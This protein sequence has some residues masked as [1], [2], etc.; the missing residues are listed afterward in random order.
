MGSSFSTTTTNH[1]IKSIFTVKELSP[2]YRYQCLNIPTQHPNETWL[3]LEMGIVIDDFLKATPLEQ[4]ELLL[5]SFGHHSTTSNHATLRLE[6]L[7]TYLK[8][9]QPTFIRQ[10]NR[11]I[12]LFRYIF[13]P[14]SFI[15]KTSVN[16]HFDLPII[17]S[18]RLINQIYIHATIN[19]S[20]IQRNFKTFKFRTE[21]L[22]KHNR[23][24]GT[25]PDG[26]IT[27]LRFSF[28]R[29]T[30][31]F[32]LVEDN[33]FTMPHINYV[34][35]D[36]LRP[37]TSTSMPHT[38]LQH[39]PRLLTRASLSHTFLHHLHGSSNK[40]DKMHYFYL[41]MKIQID[42]WIHISCLGSLITDYVIDQRDPFSIK[43]CTLYSISLESSDPFATTVDSNII[44]KL[45]NFKY[46]EAAVITIAWKFPLPSSF[47]FE[48]SYKTI[49]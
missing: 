42:Q 24:H 39:N 5:S 16:S 26:M 15:A 25:S 21:I 43:N 49:E 2:G 48:V 36:H 17:S 8:G 29:L 33:N 13:H 7:L 46:N 1:E 34:E 11:E 4:E 35:L 12:L 6:L 32:I 44:S 47:K 22:D 45:H 20:S 19:Q 40:Q 9:N 41:R 37:M 30:T 14:L 38:F 27:S 3:I 28:G 18:T 10:D 23:F 31:I